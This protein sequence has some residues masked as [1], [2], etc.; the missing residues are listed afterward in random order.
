M[1]NVVKI[2]TLELKV[3]D[4]GLFDYIYFFSEV[5]AVCMLCKIRRHVTFFNIPKR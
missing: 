1:C 5:H 3:Q 2:R 4:V